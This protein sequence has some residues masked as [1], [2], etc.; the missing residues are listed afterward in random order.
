MSFLTVGG[1]GTV[2]GGSTSTSTQSATVSFVPTVNDY[3][4]PIFSPYPAGQGLSTLNEALPGSAALGTASN[5]GTPA[6]SSDATT[7][8]ILGA[9]ALAAWYLFKGKA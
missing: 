1:G 3:G 5:A 2:S 9:V 6:T 7:L 8:L 4:D